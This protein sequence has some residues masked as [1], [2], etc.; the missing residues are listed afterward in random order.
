[1]PS[2]ARTPTASVI[3][4]CFERLRF[5]R[6][7]VAS[8]FAQTLADWELIIVD[9]GSGSAV[10]EYLLEVA[11]DAR[12]RTLRL[13][14]TGN[15]AVVRNAGL[16]RAEGKYV[17]FIDSDDVWTPRKLELQVASLRRSKELRWG[18]TAYRYIDASGQVAEG[19]GWVPHEGRALEASVRLCL[20]SALPSVI[21]ERSFVAEV[22]GFDER[23]NFYEDHDLWFRLALRSNADVVSEALVLI[24]KHDGHYSHT[25]K[26]RA[27]EC[28]AELLS[29]MHAMVDD[30]AL[31]EIAR[32]Q[33]ALCAASLARLF[34][35]ARAD[36]SRAVQT[37]LKSTTYSWPYARWWASALYTIAASLSLGLAKA[38]SSLPEQSGS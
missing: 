6:C 27:V 12:V 33:R 8:V 31:R 13:P 2:H 16:Q 38:R 1:M 28:K 9:D 29:R 20:M 21:A 15:P 32:R 7:A 36:R 30:P 4:P 35:G 37:L 24:R 18:Y 17:A 25:D 11:V 22:G 10:Q 14:H 34:L 3:L 26:L 19:P 5:L 23:Q